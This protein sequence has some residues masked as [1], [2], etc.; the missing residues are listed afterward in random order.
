MLDRL[1]VSQLRA[2]EELVCEGRGHHSLDVEYG[3]SEHFG[4]TEEESTAHAEQEQKHGHHHHQA[5]VLYHE[6]LL[7]RARPF[8][9]R[10]FEHRMRESEV[11]GA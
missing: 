7:V 3:P 4:Q 10:M 9:A 2:C 8:R 1:S 11:S 6:Y 5:D